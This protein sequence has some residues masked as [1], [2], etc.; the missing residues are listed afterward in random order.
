MAN[1]IERLNLIALNIGCCVHNGDWNWKDVRSPFSRLYY[2]SEGHAQVE[3]PSGIV[4]LKEGN[5]YYIPAYTRHSC[6]CDSVF[7]HYYIH[8][9]EDYL[10][11]AAVLDEYDL[12]VEIKACPDA[13]RIMQRL[14]EINPTLEIPESNPESYDNHQMLMVNFQKNLQRPFCDKVESRGLLYILLSK[15]LAEAK[16]KNIASD[17]RIRKV[18]SYISRNL[19][20]VLDVNQLAD[21][22]CMSK[23]H[24]SRIFKEQTGETPNSYYIKKKMEKAELLLVASDIPVKTIS[25][26]LG[27]DD[28]SYFIRMFKKYSGLTPQQYREQ[29]FEN[30]RNF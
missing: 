4:D 7:T 24:F 23:V 30:K 1:I 18:I 3:L 8:I 20:K 19:D 28:Y 21:M 11:G 27:Y 26:R 22:A 10:E 9:F 12:P 25:T 14:C 13:L 2:V 6:I 5:L 15:F 16:L 29:K 17:D